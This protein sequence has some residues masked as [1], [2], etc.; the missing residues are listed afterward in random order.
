MSDFSGLEHIGCGVNLHGR[1]SCN[2][3]AESLFLVEQFAENAFTT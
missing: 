1:M 2:R 3:P